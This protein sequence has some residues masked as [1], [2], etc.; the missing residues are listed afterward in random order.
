VPRKGPGGVLVKCDMCND[1]VHNGLKPAC[2][3]TCPTGTMNFGPRDE[4][5]AMAEERFSV[6]R[7]DYP[8]AV[9]ANAQ[10]VNVVYLLAHDPMLYHQYTIAS[11]PSP[12]ISR[13]MALRRML[14]PFA[15]AANRLTSA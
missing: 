3:K 13:H 5:L 6:V 7:K 14:R 9:L 15:R 4:M 12:G 8:K 11:A 10:D 1:R 2:V